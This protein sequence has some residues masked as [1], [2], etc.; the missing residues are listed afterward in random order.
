MSGRTSRKKPKSFFSEVLGND[1]AR[2]SS[3]A[4]D[5]ERQLRAKKK[6][7]KRAGVAKRMAQRAESRA[8]RKKDRLNK[9]INRCQV[10]HDRL[11]PAQRRARGITGYG[12][13]D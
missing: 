4:R 10:S 12:G 13:V 2:K 3:H 11:T 8:K 6:E 7:I 5:L 1:M 9:C